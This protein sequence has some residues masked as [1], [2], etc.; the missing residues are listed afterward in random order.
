MISNEKSIDKLFETNIKVN[1]KCWIILAIFSLVSFL[2]SF[3]WIEH[4]IIQDVTILFY[5]ESLSNEIEKQ[6]NSVYW[7]SLCYMVSYIPLVFPAMFLLDRKGLKLTVLLGAFLTTLGSV[8]KCASVRSDLFAVTM[9][10]Q[11]VCSVA[12]AVK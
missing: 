5:N 3:N 4:N 10:S 11:V 7:L 6:N 12:Q 9:F 2:N 8:I 1:S